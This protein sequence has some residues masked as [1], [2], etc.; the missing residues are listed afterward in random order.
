MKAK[1]IISK[2]LFVVGLFVVG[3]GVL[4]SVVLKLMELVGW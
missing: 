4:E 2:V 3:S 1:E